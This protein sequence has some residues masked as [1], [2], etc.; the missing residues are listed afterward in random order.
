MPL[1]VSVELPV[2]PIV[3]VRLLEPPTVT[4]PKSRTP[5]SEINRVGIGVKLPVSVIGPFIVTEAGLFVPEYEPLPLPIQPLKTYP[6]DTVAL[7]FTLAPLLFQILVG[8]TVPP[9]AVFIVRKYCVVKF[10][11]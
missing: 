9:V 10:P 4:L 6:F 8:L 11:V 1:T 7:M 3:N 2:L 5:L